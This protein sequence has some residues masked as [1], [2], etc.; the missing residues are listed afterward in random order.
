MV[1][2]TR[3]DPESDDNTIHGDSAAGASDGTATAKTAIENINVADSET[4]DHHGGEQARANTIIGDTNAMPMHAMSNDD[5]YLSHERPSDVCS[6]NA[7][8]AACDTQAAE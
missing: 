8:C 2:A 4:C 7:H 3:S 5:H 6:A 1:V